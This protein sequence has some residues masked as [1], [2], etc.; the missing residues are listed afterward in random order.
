[1]CG[2]SFTFPVTWITQSMVG[3]LLEQVEEVAV[4]DLLIKLA[5]TMFLP[6]R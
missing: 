1:M 4:L 6:N 3:V 5:V 2:L